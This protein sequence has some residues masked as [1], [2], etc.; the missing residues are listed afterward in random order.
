MI[1]DKDG[2]EIIKEVNKENTVWM[3]QKEAQMWEAMNSTMNQEERCR[4]AYFFW[5]NFS[6]EGFDKWY[7]GLHEGIIK[8]A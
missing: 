8:K 5:N 3:S 6:Y 1:L 7:A 2:K 4:R